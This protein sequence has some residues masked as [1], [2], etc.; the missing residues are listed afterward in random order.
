MTASF[1][2][3][4]SKITLLILSGFFLISPAAQADEPAQVP[5]KIAPMP[6]KEAGTLSLTIE[7]D[8]LNNFDR[9]YTNGVRGSWLSA[10]DDVPSW[11]QSGSK[12]L[13]P[14]QSRGRIEYALGQ[15]M[16]TPKDTSR[17]I[18]DP[19]DRPYAGWLYGSIGMIA[20]T[21]NQLDQ[22][23]LSLGVIGP[24]S[25]AGETQKAVHKVTGSQHPNGWDHQLNNEPAV[26]LTYQHSVRAFATGDIWG[27]SVD[28]TPHIGGALGNV[29]TY[30]NAGATVRFGYNLPDDYGPPRVQ[31]SLPGAGYFEAVDNFGWY[32]FAGLDGRAIAQNIFLDGNTWTDSPSVNKKPFVLDG[33]AGVALVWRD[34]RLA[35][36][37]VYRTREFNGQE[38][39]DQFG[40][41]SLSFRF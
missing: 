27:L 29:F 14:D 9:H 1:G 12:F 15:S 41:L 4:A 34:T 40:A 20:E 3:S 38:N 24:A 13:F 11:L 37:Y 39:P 21:G 8:L 17:A 26:L 5:Q 28:A 7:N 35:Y 33:Q 22:L 30:A 23:Q 2:R 18:P 10:P 31:P 25:L 36:T 6:E 32:F 19:S 16:Y